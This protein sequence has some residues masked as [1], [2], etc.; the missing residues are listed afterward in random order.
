MIGMPMLTKPRFKIGLRCPRKLSYEC[1]PE[2]ANQDQFNSQFSLLSE[3]GMKIGE[4]AKLLFPNGIEVLSLNPEDA[5]AE[6]ENYS[7]SMM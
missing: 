7:C 6:T 4:Y 2:Y 5:L 3:E 1:D